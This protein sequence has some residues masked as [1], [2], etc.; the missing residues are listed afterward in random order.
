ML[1]YFNGGGLGG[2]GVWQGRCGVGGLD[3]F[4]VGGSKRDTQIYNNI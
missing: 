1:V 3:G 4:G 2:S